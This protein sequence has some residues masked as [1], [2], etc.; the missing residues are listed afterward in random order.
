MKKKIEYLL[1][2]LLA[3]LAFA[4]AE[5]QDVRSV[6][7]VV[8]NITVDHLRA[9]YMKA[10]LPIY[11]EDGFKRLLRPRLYACRI[12]AEPAQPRRLCGYGGHG[13]GAL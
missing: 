6:P 4:S 10:F 8:V 3:V 1:P 11:G 12:S 2:S 9:D 7:R 13:H 5:A